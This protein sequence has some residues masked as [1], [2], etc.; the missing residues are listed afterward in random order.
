MLPALTINAVSL[1]SQVMPRK[2]RSKKTLMDEAVSAQA[3]REAAA[4][5][6]DVDGL[7]E[8][9]PTLGGHLRTALS[10][11]D[12]DDEEKAKRYKQVWG[13]DHRLSFEHWLRKDRPSCAVCKDR[14]PQK[15]E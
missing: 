14:E 5:E 12:S 6:A 10:R 2:Q 1:A 11:A 8:V 9:D 15:C 3:L 13:R 7:A 4:T